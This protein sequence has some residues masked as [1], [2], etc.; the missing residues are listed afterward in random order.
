MEKLGYNAEEEYF[1]APPHIRKLA[2]DGDPEAQYQLAIRYE[3]GAGVK[4]DYP[5]A[6]HW[7]T[8]A[9]NSGHLMAMKSL[10]DI[11]TRGLD[12][13]DVDKARAAQWSEKVKLAEQAGKQAHPATSTE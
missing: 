3:S 4:R 8:E 1:H 12:G 10:A 2:E 7:F 13:A 11:Y 6:L 5:Q 9:A